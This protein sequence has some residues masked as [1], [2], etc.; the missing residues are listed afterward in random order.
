MQWVNSPTPSGA[1]ATTG[2]RC[3]R[4]G[5]ALR[6]STAACYTLARGLA[7]LGHGIVLWSIGRLP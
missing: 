4:T 7:S 5:E 1:A 3:R 2:R 6:A